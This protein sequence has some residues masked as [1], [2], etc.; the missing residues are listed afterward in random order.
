[1]SDQVVVTTYYVRLLDSTRVAIE[2]GR[3][4]M[5]TDKR[6]G[7]IELTR[8][9]RRLRFSVKDGRRRGVADVAFLPGADPESY[10][11][12]AQTA[13]QTAGIACPALPRGTECVYGGVARIGS[14]P[15]ITWQWRTDV[16]PR[17]Q[18]VE[19]ASVEFHG[20]SEE[21]AMLI[22]WGFKPMSLGYIPNV[23][24]A[25]TG[26]P[27]G[28]SATDTRGVRAAGITRETATSST[29]PAV[30]PRLDGLNVQPRTPASVAAP[31]QGE[32]GGLVAR[33]L[34]ILTEET[35]KW[36]PNRGSITPG[37]RG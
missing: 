1:M 31:G 3:E 26:V 7:T 11:A 5:G 17:L 34:A 2:V 27:E 20:S 22:D 18:A 29:V 24:G 30:T 9:G 23:R 25:V 14:G 33:A 12:K 32:P 6:P 19:P 28:P 13:A 35:A 8:Q 36:N 15:V 16:L 4:R 10:L 37:G 21:G